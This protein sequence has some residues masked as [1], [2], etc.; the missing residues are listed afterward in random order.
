[1]HQGIEEIQ[2]H[3][4]IIHPDHRVDTYRIGFAGC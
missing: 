3:G 2:S 1:M 4:N